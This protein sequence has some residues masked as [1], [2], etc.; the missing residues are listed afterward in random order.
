MAH[1]LNQGPGTARLEPGAVERDK[2]IGSRAADC[3][4]ASGHEDRI[5]RPGHMTS[6]DRGAITSHRSCVA[7]VVHTSLDGAS[8]AAKKGAPRSGSFCRCGIG[9]SAQGPT[10]AFSYS[11][12]CL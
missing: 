8:I 12:A 6:P 11:T 3:I 9:L 1:R 7:E 10:C 4:R 5:N 2:L